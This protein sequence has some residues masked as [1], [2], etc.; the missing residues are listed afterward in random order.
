MKFTIGSEVNFLNEPGGG[1]IIAFMNTSTAIVLSDD[2]IE[3]PFPVAQLVPKSTQNQKSEKK[4]EHIS[5]LELKERLKKIPVRKI[6]IEKEKN[7][8][9]KISKPQDFKE[10]E[11]DLH[12]E[13]LLPS[14]AGMSNAE[15]ITVQLNYFNRA[16]DSAMRRNVHKIVF[17]HGVGK[18]K[19]KE[20]IHKILKSH[21][22]IVFRSAPYEKYG[23]GATEVIFR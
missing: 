18:G 16:L 13:N 14:H 21:S 2:D 10:E 8:S 23:W 19:L 1:K 15:I 20:E 22:D 6:V 17:I 4:L 5:E 3:I 12:I 9:K 7:D 11:V